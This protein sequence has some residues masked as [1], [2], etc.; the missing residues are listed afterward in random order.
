VGALVTIPVIVGVASDAFPNL[1]ILLVP[2]CW[3][4]GWLLSLSLFLVVLSP[5]LDRRY[6]LSRDREEPTPDGQT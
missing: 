4:A 5:R 2:A 6:P 3:I 1:A